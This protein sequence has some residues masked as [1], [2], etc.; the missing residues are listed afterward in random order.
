MMAK[1][2]VANPFAR[3][4]STYRNPR[5][6]STRGVVLP[7]AWFYPR[8]GSTRGVVLPAAWFY[9]RRLVGSSI[10]SR[11]S[12]FADQRARTAAE[13]RVDH[14][15][16]RVRV[17]DEMSLQ[18]GKHWTLYKTRRARANDR[19]PENKTNTLC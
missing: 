13:K 17:I 9:P 16:G 18:H 12:T 10:R 8:R 11:Y 19:S 3:R 14:A 15:R 5:R 7:A 6:G 4:R 2:S 1:S